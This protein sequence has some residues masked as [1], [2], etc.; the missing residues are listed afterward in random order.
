LVKKQV[1]KK[2]EDMTSEEIDAEVKSM[3]NRMAEIVEYYGK[4]L[5]QLMKDMPGQKAS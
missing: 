3:H 1:R 5:Q 2:L 4:K